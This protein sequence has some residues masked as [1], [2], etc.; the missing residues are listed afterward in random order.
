MSYV[1]IGS[2]VL[3]TTFW[4]ILFKWRSTYLKLDQDGH[5]FYVKVFSFLGSLMDPYILLGYMCALISSVLWIVA[6][7]KVP[8]SI[9]YPFL[10]LPMVFVMLAS[11]YIFQETLGFYKI[12]GAI[13]IITGIILIGVKST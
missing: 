6:L 4:Q 13:L 8:L 5:S 3:L 12:L 9:A 7:K 2:V 10:S 1:F 11:Y